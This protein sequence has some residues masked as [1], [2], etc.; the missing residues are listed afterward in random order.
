[1]KSYKNKK[2]V[3][4]IIPARGGSKGIKLKNLR[5]VCGKP[6]IYYPIRAAIKSR[7][8]D[9]ILVSTDCEKIKKEAIKFGAE[10]PFLRKKKYSGDKISTEKTLKNALTEAEIFYNTSFDICVFLTCTNIFRKAAWIRQAVN[11]LKK[12]SSIDSSFSVHSFYKHLWHKVNGIFCKTSNWMH[13]YTSRQVGKKIFR[14][15][16]GLALASRSKFWRNGKRIGKKVHFIV[17]SDPFTGI[18]IHT[19]KDLYLAEMAMRYQKKN[20]YIDH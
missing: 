1:M 11:T 20:K 18:D 14:E 6:L 15:D 7:V 4:C 19:E 9:R 13:S 2:S 16:T 10:V 8:C 12:N 5:K 3:I 17:N